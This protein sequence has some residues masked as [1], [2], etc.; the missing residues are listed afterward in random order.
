MRRLG[1]TA[2]PINE[3][4]DEDDYSDNYEDDSF[5]SDEQE[6]ISTGGTLE[7]PLLAQ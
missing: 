2:Q 5:E 1:E 7:T 6:P 3:T 4:N